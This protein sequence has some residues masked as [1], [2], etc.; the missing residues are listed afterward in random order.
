MVLTRPLPLLVLPPARVARELLHSREAEAA[1][2]EYQARLDHMLRICL[3][4]W[5]IGYALA[6]LAFR[7]TEVQTGQ[8]LLLFAFVVILV[9]PMWTLIIWHWLG[10][11]E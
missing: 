8:F 9:A 6:M 2:R 7:V 10:G 1:M 5:I 3:F 4:E 11:Q